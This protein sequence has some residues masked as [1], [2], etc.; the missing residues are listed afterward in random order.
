MGSERTWTT[1]SPLIVRERILPYVSIEDLLYK[2]SSN[3]WSKEETFALLEDEECFDRQRIRRSHH[4][5]YVYGANMI[6]VYS[7]KKIIVSLW[8]KTMM[9]F[10][11]A[12]E[13]FEYNIGWF[14][15]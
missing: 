3:M 8:K 14:L 2:Q 13:H 11:D 1:A 12:I 10:E 6:A 5:D 15:R 9:S 7:V 4:R